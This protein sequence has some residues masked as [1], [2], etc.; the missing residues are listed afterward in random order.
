M[1]ELIVNES[2]ETKIFKIRNR[3]VMTDDDLALIYGVETKVLNQ[4]VKRNIARFPNNFR[5]QLTLDEV[6][7]LRSQSVTSKT[8]GGRRYLP[9]VF[10]EQGVAMLSAVLK[11]KTAI[12]VSIQI[13]NTFVEMRTFLIANDT[14]L[15]KIN[16]LEANQL[17]Y[18]NQT[19]ER[20]DELFKALEN[21]SLDYKQGVFYDGQIFDAYLFISTLIKK[22][23]KSIVLIDNY[24]DET[25]LTHLSK[26]NNK[27]KITILTKNISELLQLDIKKYNKQ[28]K[29]IQIKSFDLSHDRFLL[30]DS[31]AL[32]HL[33]ASIKDLGKKWFAFSKMDIDSVDFIK[34]IT[35]FL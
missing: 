6:E 7:G 28:Y 1:N 24:I 31:Q 9:Y 13:I 11:S 33:G 3:L 23:Q 30:L 32:Y 20:F 34:K 10:T 19:E 8:R 4:A 27:V 29:N 16:H 21:K 22:A 26:A 5:F 12:N 14:L 25:V 2:I 35:P 18:K 15:Q 17:N